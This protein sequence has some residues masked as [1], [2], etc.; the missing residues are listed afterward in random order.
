MTVDHARD[1]GRYVLD[2]GWS[3]Q[4]GSIRIARWHRSYISDASS[5]SEAV[6][7]PMRLPFRANAGVIV[8]SLCVLGVAG[9]LGE[10]VRASQPYTITLPVPPVIPRAASDVRDPASTARTRHAAS[11]RPVAEH[12]QV[13]NTKP[14][15]HPS[16]ELSLGTSDDVE[17]QAGIAPSRTAAIKIALLS[18]DMQ[19]WQDASGVRGFVVAGPLEQGENGRCR[20][21]AMLTRSTSG[22][23]VEQRR[24]CLR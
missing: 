18:G 5:S 7:K 1:A 10:R 16:L 15:P 3:L 2:R 24:E 9:A 21:M 17:A 11:A 6:R 22:D 12:Q 13:A 20:A 19:E 23:N 14:A 8:F 4:V